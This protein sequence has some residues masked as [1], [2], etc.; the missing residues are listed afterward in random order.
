MLPIITHSLEQLANG[1]DTLSVT[2]P[3][4]AHCDNTS[5]KSHPL[6]PPPPPAVC[7]CVCAVQGPNA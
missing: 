3:A 1:R 2:A 5:H 6:T 4:P 7:V